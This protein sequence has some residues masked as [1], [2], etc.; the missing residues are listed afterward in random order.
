MS[1]AVAANSLETDGSLPVNG[2]IDLTVVV[3]PSHHD[4]NPLRDRSPNSLA[5]T[6]SAAVESVAAIAP[7]GSDV[8][9]PPVGAGTWMALRD[10]FDG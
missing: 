7:P 4:A 10:A 9:I 3:I 2:M 6:L 5:T 1:V 8:L